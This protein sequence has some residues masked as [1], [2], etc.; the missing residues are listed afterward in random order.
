MPPETWARCLDRLPPRLRPDILEYKRLLDRSARLLARLLVAEGLK[1]MGFG[2]DVFLNYR[3]DE[4]GRPYVRGAVDF[5]VSHS[6]ELVVCCIAEEGRVGVDVE[7]TRIVDLS[8][9]RS[10]LDPNTWKRI[11]ESTDPTAAFFDSWTRIES[12]LKAEGSGLAVEPK[13]VRL[14]GGVAELSD[15]TWYLHKVEVHPDYSCSVAT[16]TKTAEISL[17]KVDIVGPTAV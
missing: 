8:A 10:R 1:R 3:G 16:D 11:E 2:G 12:V 5:N 17:Q 7:R 15:T 4:N 14:L 9:F 6:E 13:Q